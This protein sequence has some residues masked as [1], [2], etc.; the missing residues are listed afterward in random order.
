VVVCVCVRVRVRVRVSVPA[1]VC[2]CVCAGHRVCRFMRESIHLGVRVQKTKAFA[3]IVCVCLGLYIPRHTQAI[4][5]FAS[6]LGQYKNV[7]DQMSLEKTVGGEQHFVS[8]VC[9][10]NHPAG[11]AE[12]ET[13]PEPHIP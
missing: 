5:A 6:T 12:A 7:T 9:S 4:H 11:H 2:V 10:Q 13:I 1:C 3:C 8:T